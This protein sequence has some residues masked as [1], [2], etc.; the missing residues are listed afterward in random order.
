MLHSLLSP[1][2]IYIFHYFSSISITSFLL[3][4]SLSLE[5]ELFGLFCLL[6]LLG[7]LGRLFGLLFGLCLSCC[8]RM[9]S[10]YSCLR[11]LVRFIRLGLLA[12]Y[13]FLSSRRYS[14][15]KQNPIFQ[16]C[17]VQSHVLNSQWFANIFLHMDSNQK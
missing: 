4:I 16:L 14:K 17:I 3:F 12:C 10:R 9:G 1:S 6:G 13:C 5:V 8:G 7:G 2:S 15:I 11:F